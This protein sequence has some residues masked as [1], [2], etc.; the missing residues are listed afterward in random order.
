[1]PVFASKALHR[2]FAKLFIINSASMV[3][4]ASFAFVL[5]SLSKVFSLNMV[6]GDPRI[7]NVREMTFWGTLFVRSLTAALDPLV[8]VV[9]NRDLSRKTFRWLSGRRKAKVTNYPQNQ[10]NRSIELK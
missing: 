9:F 10:P 7:D 1:M 3:F 2:K 8:L 5:Y 6:K 4:S